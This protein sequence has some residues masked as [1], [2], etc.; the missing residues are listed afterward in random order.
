MNDVDISAT[1]M[2]MQNEERPTNEGIRKE[3]TLERSTTPLNE[4]KSVKCVRNMT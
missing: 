1:A 2:R 3:Q 4:N